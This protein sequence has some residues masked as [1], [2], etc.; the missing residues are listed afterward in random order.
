MG[1][2][3]GDVEI[4]GCEAPEARTFVMGGAVLSIDGRLQHWLV[5]IETHGPGR[6]GKFP[7]PDPQLHHV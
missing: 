3:D 4:S 6:Y 5:R 1:G 7:E 2:A